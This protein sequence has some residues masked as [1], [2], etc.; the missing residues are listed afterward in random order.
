MP[1]KRRGSV[2]ITPTDSENE[3]NDEEYEDIYNHSP[4][5][6][7]APE[8]QS[9][10][11]QNSTYTEMVMNSISFHNKKVIEPSY[12]IDVL[13]PEPDLDEDMIATSTLSFLNVLDNLNE[14]ILEKIE[15]A[16]QNYILQMKEQS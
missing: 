10:M 15:Y 7:E 3:D 9:S 11:F 5:I 14:I 16:K 13:V 12:S 8:R 2:E 1:Q 4:D 6:P